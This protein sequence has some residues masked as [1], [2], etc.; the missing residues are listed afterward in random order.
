MF[1]KPYI[2]IIIISGVDPTLPP[3]DKYDS[4]I[5][6]VFG[7]EIHSKSQLPEIL[8]PHINDI[9]INRNDQNGGTLLHSALAIKSITSETVKMLL[10]KGANPMLKN[11]KEHYDFKSDLAKPE[12]V[13]KISKLPIEVA[14]E[15][16]TGE[17]ICHVIFFFLTLSLKKNI[18]KY[19]L[20]LL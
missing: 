9:N 16:K 8:T 5:I 17:I 3:G 10:E 7:S 13:Y 14:D 6:L 19:L 4:A 11:H 18:D 15:N 2:N 12:H 1:S 20:G